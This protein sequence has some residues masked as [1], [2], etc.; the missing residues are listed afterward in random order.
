MAM[1]LGHWQLRGY[2]LWALVEKDS[3]RLIGRAGFF[4][5]EGW[6]GFEIGWMLV[7]S[8]WGKG[9]AFEGAGAA[10]DYGRKVLK[11]Q[12]IISVIHEHNQASMRLAERLGAVVER[13]MVFRGV[14]VVVYR[15]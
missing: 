4:N 13:E 7:K 12:N 6:P 3:D 11:R 8:H 10:L 9:L 14:P 2:G 5:P 1:L 15:H